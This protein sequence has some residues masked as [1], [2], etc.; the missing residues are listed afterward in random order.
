M[1]T[2]SKK[3]VF[4]VERI[5][6]DIRNLLLELNMHQ[7]DKL[8]DNPPNKQE[9]IARFQAIQAAIGRFRK[10]NSEF[11]ERNGLTE[12]E[13]ISSMN[14]LPKGSEA[15]RMMEQSN[16]LKIDLLLSYAT[17]FRKMYE[18]SKKSPLFEQGDSGGTSFI[19]KDSQKKAVKQKFKA[20]S[21]RSKWKK[22]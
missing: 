22:M 5:L 21:Q 20:M 12:R 6:G 1:S 15:E 19:S 3:Q 10:F 11:F 4:V 16:Q 7:D 8:K 14:T 2:P 9:I 13:L 17:F 18:K